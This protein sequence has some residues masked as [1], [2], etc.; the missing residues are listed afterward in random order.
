VAI[1]A[2]LAVAATMHTARKQ[3]TADLQIAARQVEASFDLLTKQ[4]E[5]QNSLAFSQ[6]SAARSQALEEIKA[7]VL[8]KNRQEWINDLRNTLANF[9][10]AA[11]KC[12]N[13]LAISPETR[14]MAR[15]HS[16]VDEAWLHLTR[17]RLLINP[18]EKDHEDLLVTANLMFD[19]TRPAV[20]N[21]RLEDVERQLLVKGQEILKREWERVKLLA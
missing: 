17:L 2:L 3:R 11:H 14:D 5:S 8:T 21:P 13:N 12:R 18:K 1:G 16:N 19:L 20:G 4:M 7:Q 6:I 15:I 10:V 9:I